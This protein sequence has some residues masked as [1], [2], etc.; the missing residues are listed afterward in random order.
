MYTLFGLILAG[1]SE[2]QIVRNTRMRVGDTQGNVI[3]VQGGQVEINESV[4]WIQVKALIGRNMR[5][6]CICKESC[7]AIEDGS[8]NS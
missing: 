1:D 2:R 3:E 6:E 8:E 5:A 7:M 4:K